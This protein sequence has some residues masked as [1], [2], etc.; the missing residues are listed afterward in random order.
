MAARK[1]FSPGYAII[2]AILILSLWILLLN[3]I[4]TERGQESLFN[5]FR[6]LS[7]VEE[8]EKLEAAIGKELLRLG[9]G[10]KSIEKA[11]REEVSRG[12]IKW[13]YFRKEIRIPL[14]RPLAD[15]YMAIN[16]ALRRNG[17]RIFECQAK[18]KGNENFLTLKA[19]IESFPTHSFLLKQ[20]PQIALIIDDFGYRMSRRER[21]F[22]E[23]EFP[24]TVSVIP[25]LTYS[26][27]AAREAAQKGKEVILHLPMEPREDL[28]NDYPWIILTSMNRRQVERAVEESLASIPLAVGINNHMGSK[29]T[30]DK[31]V[32]SAILG[33]AK[34]KS[35][36]YIDSRTSNKSVAFALAKKMK[37]RTGRNNIFLDNYPGDSRHIRKQLS[38]LKKIALARGQA[39]AI[40]H[41][42]RSATLSAVKEFLPQFKKE[43]IRLVYVS[44][45]TE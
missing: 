34:K 22:L 10:T 5:L 35:V 36:F 9:V 19:G 18:K 2:G 25:G 23:A 13:I 12:R 29:A 39:I 3:S 20:S 26:A 40:G 44:E 42:T 16:E 30:E 37:V 11:Y 17:G 21:G 31:E 32:M 6:P 14:S 38:S 24:L 41:A 33:L 28:S 43:G 15:Y 27:E 8:S 45:L 1:K 4:Q 7:Y